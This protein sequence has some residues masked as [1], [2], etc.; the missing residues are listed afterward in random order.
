MS[1]KRGRQSRHVRFEMVNDPDE[2]LRS[3]LI[4]MLRARLADTLLSSYGE[5]YLGK[6][7]IQSYR[8]LIGSG[9]TTD[10]ILSKLIAVI[11]ECSYIDIKTI[12]E[13]KIN[14]Q[15]LDDTQQ[16]ESTIINNMINT[17]EMEK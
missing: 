3:E 10:E 4:I 12:K 1:L 7:S 15:P 11:L 5:R 17:A 14:S 16:D 13:M 8:E 9:R 6:E 2:T